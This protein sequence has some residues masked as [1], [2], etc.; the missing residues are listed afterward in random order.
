[1][2][3]AMSFG[4]LTQMS[5]LENAVSPELEDAVF[6]LLESAAIVQEPQQPEA[7]LQSSYHQLFNATE[8]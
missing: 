7:E 1:M 3:L 8:N 2:T 5:L 4:L 6:L